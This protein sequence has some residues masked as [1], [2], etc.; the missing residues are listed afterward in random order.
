MMEQTACLVKTVD[1]YAKDNCGQG[2][3]PI[4][5]WRVRKEELAHQRQQTEQIQNGLIGVWSCQE[6]ASSFR[7]RY[8]EKSGY[9]Q[10]QKYQTRCNHLYFYFD[11]D[12]F[13]F[14]NIRLQTWFPYHIQICLNLWPHNL[15]RFY[16][17][18]VAT[19]QSWRCNPA[20]PTFWPP[21]TRPGGVFN[22]LVR[23]AGFRID[24]QIGEQGFKVWPAVEQVLHVIGVGQVLTNGVSA[25]MVCSARCME[26][27]PVP[28]GDRGAGC[29]RTAS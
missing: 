15:V 21:E 16:R 19:E 12:E 11:H 4:P 26:L 8:C 29:E 28:G 24:I 9:P 1:E 2:I 13:G 10:L 18:G 3:I 22:T 14:M 7:A 25:S 23:L 17:N 6:A 20:G 27:S 5:S